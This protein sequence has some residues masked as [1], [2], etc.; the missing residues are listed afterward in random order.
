MSKAEFRVDGAIYH[1]K[2]NKRVFKK[3]R[4][5]YGMRYV[6]G[7]QYGEVGNILTS[8]WKNGDIRILA[9]Y[10]KDIISGDTQ[11]ADILVEGK[12]NSFRCPN[13]GKI[14]TLRKDSF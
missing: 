9:T 13:C 8:E 14:I 1:I 11:Y 5:T 3:L 2:E 4:L 12:E 7:G 6:K 10:V